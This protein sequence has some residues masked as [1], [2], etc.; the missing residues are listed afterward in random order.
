MSVYSINPVWATLF[1]DIKQRKALGE[2]VTELQEKL[3]TINQ[4]IPKNIIPQVNVIEPIIQEQPR[5]QIRRQQQPQPKTNDIVFGGVKYEIGKNKKYKSIVQVANKLNVTVADLKKYR[6]SS[7]KKRVFVKPTGETIEVDLTKKKPLLLREFGIKR[8]ADKQLIKETNKFKRDDTTIKMYQELP[9]NTSINV[10]IE[11]IVEFQISEETVKRK[12]QFKKS[13]NTGDDLKPYIIDEIINQGYP[14]NRQEL[15]SSLNNKSVNVFRNKERGQL[16]NIQDMIL[17]DDTPPSIKNFYSNVIESKKWKHCIHDYL[18]DIYKGLFSKKI[19][20]LNTTNDILDFCVDKNIKMVAYDITGKCIASNYPNKSKSK[21]KNLFFI[22][23]N[24]HLY[25][26]ESQ[27]L[28]KVKPLIKQIE[29]ITDAN[30][31]IINILENGRYPSN[32][33]MFG[34]EIISFIDE[35]TKYIINDEYLKCKE[36]LDTF[37]LTDKIYDGISLKSIGKIIAPLYIKES[38][39]SIF[40]NHQKFVKGGFNYN[41]DDIKG[42]YK[43]IDANKF[44]PSCLRDL[45]YIIKI[46]MIRNDICNNIDLDED[47]YLYIVKPEMSSI[48]LPDTNCY[49]GEFLKYCKNEGLKFTILEK[50]EATAI[51]NHY[52]DFIN[53]LYKR[54]DEDTFKKIM[55]PFIGSFEP[56]SNKKIKTV[57]KKFANSDEVNCITENDATKQLN[58]NLNIVFGYQETVS[59]YDKK[60]IAIQIKD[61]SRKRLYELMKLLKLTN[62]NIKSI[63]TDCIAFVSNVDVPKKLIGRGLGEWKFI[64]Y[65]NISAG[66]NFTD[67]YMT[68]N[69]D[70]SKNNSNILGLCYAG[71][72]KTHKIINTHIKNLG[73]DYI[74]LT[75]SHT[76]L[77]SYRNKKLNCNVIQKYEYSNEPI[78]YNTIIIDEIGMCSYKAMTIILEN[79]YLG[80]QIIAYGDFKQLLPVGELK[81]LMSKLFQ[82]YVFNEIE[83]MDT[84]YRN[85]FSRNFYDDIINEKFNN[86]DLIKKYRDINSKNVLCLTR[87]TRD[88]YNLQIA[89][90]YG[91]ENVYDIGASIIVKGNDLADKGLYNRFVY[92]VVDNIDGVAVLNNGVEIDNDKM[93]RY[94]EFAY[95]R[96]LHS[97]QGSELT[98]FWFPDDDLKYINRLDGRYTYTLISRLKGMNFD[99]KKDIPEEINIQENEKHKCEVKCIC[100]CDNPKYKIIKLTEQLFCINCS[101][102]KCRCCID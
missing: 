67:D 81:P 9:I 80:K 15:E 31:K 62:D 99:F 18:N 39:N 86:I 56:S 50:I 2:D 42:Q 53:E 82:N 97:Y 35:T 70:I 20:K 74:V 41:N 57:F 89:A 30:T 76:S 34:S 59:I 102:F 38:D 14:V 66:F 27:Y 73:N 77:D 90:E 78:N 83:V 49:T 24:N 12:I 36:I 58:D 54:V 5:I 87:D 17:R 21:R 84:N 64:D 75:P 37:G 28:N 19:E 93:T 3:K 22:A 47:E 92:K 63:N 79:Y 16:M 45:D 61:E 7:N 85:N 32:V 23:H 6:D 8:I 46:N 68:F 88:K 69:N 11:A 29:I 26:L 10:F 91:F 101:K 98:D 1:T 65:K 13:I 55:N 72:G 95:A 60:P 40:I 51:D 48:L 52:K 25:P 4:K 100:K 33:N 96:T 71:A 44:Y 94:F 43:C